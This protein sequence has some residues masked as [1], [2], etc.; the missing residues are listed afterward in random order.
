M[1]RVETR[2]GWV[3]GAVRR[4]GLSLAKRCN[5][6]D[7]YPGLNPEGRLPA[8]ALPR[9]GSLTWNTKLRFPR[10]ALHPAGNR[11]GA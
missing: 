4:Q 6:A 11:R 2:I 5:A 9:Y 1:P 3:Q 7:A 10:L 8:G